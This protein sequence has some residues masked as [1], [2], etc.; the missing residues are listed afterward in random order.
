MSFERVWIT[1]AGGMLGSTLNFLLHGERSNWTVR[2]TTRADFDL[3]NARAVYDF[4]SDYRPTL[5]FHCAA[6]VYGL[7][8]HLANP[9]EAERI[10]RVIDL[11]VFEALNQYPRT[12]IVYA[13]SVAAYP[14]HADNE[15]FS[16]DELL[17]GQPHPDE[18]GY[19]LQKRTAILRLRELTK[20]GTDYV[21][22][23]LTNLYGPG[24]RFDVDV[25]HVAA[26]LIARAANMPNGAYLPVWGDGS[27]RRD[28]MHVDD[29]A[30]A[31]LT[32]AEKGD[33]CFNIATGVSTPVGEVA[34]IIAEQFGLPGVIYSPDK[35]KGSPSRSFDV[36]R[37]AAVGFEPRWPVKDGVKSTCDWYKRSRLDTDLLDAFRADEI[38]I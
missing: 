2:P 38:V 29:A 5:V 1:G 11:N 17:I 16:E 36:S 30:R 37:L 20:A 15:Q 12:K 26:S 8:G 24:D 19:A 4:V 28:F 14:D 35:P 10:N 22:C 6:R 21:Y 18:L 32:L 3:T 25:G 27:T 23:A 33:G 9:M 34:E 31:M 13:G 7:G